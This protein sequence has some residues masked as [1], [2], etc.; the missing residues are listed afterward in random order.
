GLVTT[1]NDAG[2]AASIAQAAAR[3]GALYATLACVELD[4]HFYYSIN[5]RIRDQI[6]RLKTFARCEG[7]R[8][9]PSGFSP[10]FCKWCGAAICR[11][12]QGGQAPLASSLRRVSTE[13]S[14]PRQLVL[15]PSVHEE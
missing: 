2:E 1:I 3:S 7:V 15:R 14:E 6:G 12:F 5:S 8:R 13:S 11:G 10:R 4:R 9:K